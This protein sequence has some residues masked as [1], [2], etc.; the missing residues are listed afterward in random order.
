MI[1]ASS[2]SAAIG[3][4][5]G[6]LSVRWVDKGGHLYFPSDLDFGFAGERG[7]DAQV[8]QWLSQQ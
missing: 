6:A 7:L 3:Q 8:L 4:A 5:S 2:L 1:P